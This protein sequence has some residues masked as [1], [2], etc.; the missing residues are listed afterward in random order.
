MRIK[1]TAALVGLV[2]AA[3]LVTGCATQTA[4]TAEKVP[5]LVV[6]TESAPS[7]FPTETGA[8]TDDTESSSETTSSGELTPATSSAPSTPTT[9]APPPTSSTSAPA[10]TGS[11]A[12]GQSFTWQNGLRISIAAGAP[13]TPSDY[14]K[15]ASGTTPTTFAVTVVNGMTGV[16]NP[17]RLYFQTQ[18]GSTEAKQIFDSGKGISGSPSASVLPGKSLT[19]QV[20]F[21][22]ADP[23]DVVIQAKAGYDYED[24][25]FS[26][27]GTASSGQ[28]SAPQPTGTA[29]AAP[30]LVKFGQ[31]FRWTNGV[32]IGVAKPTPFTPGQYS[33]KKPAKA[34]LMFTVTIVNKSG[35]AFDPSSLQLSAVSGGT[36]ASR[37]YDSDLGSLP[38]ATILNGRTLSFKVGYG[39]ADPKD[40][41]MQ[42]QPGYKY[43]IAF[44]TS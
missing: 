34:Y 42:V 38:S 9:P 14:V 11:I 3:A 33:S 40:V 19:F 36:A 1:P 39:V 21:A 6:T 7:A 28:G 23:K 17:S 18:S 4:G 13:F 43:V 5:G 2:A 41:V 16:F 27:D 25:I 10:G 26:S 24:A 8:S 12:F 30:E 37:V 32:E 31:G 15:V 44:F 29:A 22:V 35:A 20:G